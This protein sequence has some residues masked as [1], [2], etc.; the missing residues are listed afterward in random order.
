MEVGHAHG[1]EVETRTFIKVVVRTLDRQG[2]RRMVE[3]SIKV[4][5]DD[6]VVW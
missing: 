6:R 5:R 2:Q 1:Q 4:D 3:R